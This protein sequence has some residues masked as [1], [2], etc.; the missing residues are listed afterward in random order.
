[1][2]FRFCTHTKCLP[3][4]PQRGSLCRGAGQ[5]L[6]ALLAAVMQTNRAAEEDDVVEAPPPSPPAP[7]GEVE[8]ARD[9]KPR[10]SAEACACDPRFL[11]VCLFGFPLKRATHFLQQLFAK[12]G[13]LSEF[14]AFKVEIATRGQGPHQLN[15]PPP[16]CFLPQLLFS[17]HLAPPSPR[18]AALPSNCLSCR[19]SLPC[20]T[21]ASAPQPEKRPTPSRAKPGPTPEPPAPPLSGKA[22]AGP[23]ESAP[24]PHS[25]RPAPP[26]TVGRRALPVTAADAV[27]GFEVNDGVHRTFV[28]EAMAGVAGGGGKGR[29]GRLSDRHHRVLEGSNSQ[30]AGGHCGALILCFFRVF[31]I[32]LLVFF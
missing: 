31:S 29:S 5:V 13:T 22:P 32:I 21:P 30:T 14:S 3:T 12:K 28:L 15:A 23:A 16:L 9:K 19:Q 24:A 4:P 18:N 26:A 2:S 6:Q 1:M 20:P 10:P 17:S 11:C 7:L 25:P 27:S 8:S